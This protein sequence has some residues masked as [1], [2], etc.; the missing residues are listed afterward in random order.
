[1]DWIF[2]CCCTLGPLNW[3][4]ACQ[5]FGVS[6]ESCSF[7]GLAAQTSL[8]L[9]FASHPRPG[10]NHTQYQHCRQMR[11][12]RKVA[13]CLPTQ[14]P[15]DKW[16]FPSR[17]PWASHSMIISFVLSPSNV[18]WGWLCIQIF[19]LIFLRNTNLFHVCLQASPSAL[20]PFLPC[21]VLLCFSNKCSARFVLHCLLYLL[22]STRFAYM[23]LCV[24]WS[25]TDISLSVLGELLG[26][27][28]LSGV[29]PGWQN[30]WACRLTFISQNYQAFQKQSCFCQAR[31]ANPGQ[32]LNIHRGLFL[33]WLLL[34]EKHL[35][36][37][38][39]LDK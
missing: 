3:Q 20:S 14:E 30:W 22:M 35:K 38:S 19:S 15:R 12:E 36:P 37:H 24:H 28:L 4:Y 13:L 33:K 31:W 1:M 9:L 34:N 26:L 6:D 10:F 18:M 17:P 25:G 39:S 29:C 32:G 2:E 16:L 21:S 7:T 27:Q 8:W 11:K 23:P 5:H